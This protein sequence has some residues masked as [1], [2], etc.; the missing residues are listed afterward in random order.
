MSYQ[1]KYLKYKSK[2]L[3][4][5]SQ[6]NTDNSTDTSKP[7]NIVNL[8]QLGGNFV[9]KDE[10]GLDITNLTNTPRLTDIW[11][12]SYKNNSN[13]I[14][15]LIKLLS[16]SDNVITTELEGGSEQDSEAVTKSDNSDSSS[17]K[18]DNS[19]SSS[20]SEKSPS[21]KSPSEN[22]LEPEQSQSDNKSP[23][24]QSSSENK[25]P[26]EQEGGAKKKPNS[27]KKFFFE[28]SDLGGSSTTSDSELS[29][30]DTSSSN[31]S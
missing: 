20:Q 29:S 23:S 9:N 28:D 24:E 3:A 1:Q 16:D 22:T 15:N 18:S 17:D 21:E 19:S 26:S 5:K 11:G 27:Y 31:D 13:D 7:N 4:L 25:S 8:I 2:Y 6:N 14:N 10:D 12:G 30:F